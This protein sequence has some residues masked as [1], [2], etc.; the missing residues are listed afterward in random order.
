MLPQEGCGVGRDAETGLEELIVRLVDRGLAR[1][2]GESVENHAH[3]VNGRNVT[4]L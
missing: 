4:I 3:R 1:G 2:H